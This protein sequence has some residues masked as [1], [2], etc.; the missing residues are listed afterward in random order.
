MSKRQVW[1]ITLVVTVLLGVVV[2]AIFKTDKIYTHLFYIP[3]ALTA[4][5]Y[6]KQTLLIG[7]GFGFYHV[8]IEYMLRGMMEYTV[9]IRAFLIVII[10]GILSQI[11]TLDNM[12]K[13]QID[14][15]FYKSTH[16]DLTTL[17]NRGHFDRVLHDDP[18]LPLAVFICDIDNLKQT[19]DTYGHEM[20][21]QAIIETASILC[22]AIRQNDT[23]ARLGGDE[24]GVIAP[25]CDNVEADRI[26]QRIH[27]AL[28]DL[29]KEKDRSYPLSFSLGYSV[30]HESHELKDACK[31]A[32][33]AMYEKKVSKKQKMA[34]P[35]HDKNLGVKE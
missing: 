32:D 29:N 31:Y 5:F 28:S 2:S 25:F 7:I 20:G 12:Y 11:G 13:Q 16:D 34:R 23:L 10:S 3:I 24:F 27:R 9:L 33:V 22:R 30:C 18:A 8:L 35:T 26:Y 19:N 1:H 14:S 4:V 17:Y 15:L 6:P 21:D